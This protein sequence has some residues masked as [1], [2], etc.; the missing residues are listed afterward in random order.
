MKTEKIKR[1][2]TGVSLSALLA[3]SG[4]LSLPARALSQSGCSG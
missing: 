4:G 2:L 1:M 3:A